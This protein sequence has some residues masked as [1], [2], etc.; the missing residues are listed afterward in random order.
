[1]AKVIS[2]IDEADTSLRDNI[3]RGLEAMCLFRCTE[4]ANPFKWKSPVKFDVVFSINSDMMSL[5]KV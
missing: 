3:L 5:M 1:M 4:S 2:H